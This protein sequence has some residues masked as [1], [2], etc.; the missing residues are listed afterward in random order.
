MANM[1][2][3]RFQNTV[4][5]LEACVNAIDESI[6]FGEPMDLSEDE[7]RAFERMYTL[8]E[9]MQRSMEKVTQTELICI[10]HTD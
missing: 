7:Q 1:S 9:G 6:E 5:D 4:M 8:I 10:I 3:C 2:Y